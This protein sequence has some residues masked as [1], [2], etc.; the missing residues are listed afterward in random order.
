MIYKEQRF[1]RSSGTQITFEK[2]TFVGRVVQNRRRHDCT[3]QML[4]ATKPKEYCV[5]VDEHNRVVGAEPRDVTV[6]NR[7][8]GRGSYV[9]VTNDLGELL[10]SKRSMKKDVYPGH[11]DVVIAGVVQ[12][13][14]EY[15]D[16]AAREL[17]EEIGVSEE[18]ARA[19]LRRL[20][21]FPYRDA[22]CHV[23]GCAFTFN[24]SGG[25]LRLQEDEVDWAGFRSWEQVGQ[26]LQKEQFT[27]VGRH[28]LELY[29][30]PREGPQGGPQK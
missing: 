4:H 6:R 19:G 24:H 22:T 21:V 11:W 14:E 18:G 13:G 27:P 10:V 28:I 25:E 16:T 8:L 30:G 12:A 7:L 23:W 17:S 1:I 3:S 2:H 15:E 9:F 20:F 26:M 29:R 5:I